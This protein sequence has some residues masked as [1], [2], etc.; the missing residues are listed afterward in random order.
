MSRK[1]KALILTGV[2]VLMIAVKV[3]VVYLLLKP[4]VGD[5]LSFAGNW[6][7]LRLFAEDKYFIIA[8]ISIISYL[9]PALICV[10]ALSLI[11][12]SRLKKFKNS[13]FDQLYY[14]FAGIIFCLVYNLVTLVNAILR[15]LR[16]TVGYL[17]PAPLF[18]N[19]INS[20]LNEI[21]YFNLPIYA[22]FFC[23]VLWFID[24]FIHKKIGA[25]KRPKE[26]GNQI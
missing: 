17:L 16:I 9:V 26:S 4:G 12:Y 2:F 10:L 14:V 21:I 8:L 3:V 25:E 1:M 11:R 6:Y 18:L 24:W 22:Y 23:L 5:T 19:I 13:I 7:Y 15:F 20:V